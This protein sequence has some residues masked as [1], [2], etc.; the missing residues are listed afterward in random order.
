[1][2]WE[3]SFNIDQ[4]VSR[5]TQ[6]FW[7][8]GYEATSL[9]DILKATGINRGSFY[10]AFGSKK[11]IFILALTKYDSEERHNILMELTQLENPILAISV[12]F[13]VLVEKRIKDSERKGCFLVNTALDLP[14]HDKDITV[15]VKKSMESFELFFEQQITLGKQEDLISDDIDTKA[16]TKLLLALVIAIGALSR[17]ISDAASLNIIKSQAIAL[18]KK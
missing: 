16:T 17:G 15:K 5:A 7:A 9:A 6:V 13:E 11:E 8:K 10:N 2:P 12:F 1:M 14:N 3:K 18:I 4:A